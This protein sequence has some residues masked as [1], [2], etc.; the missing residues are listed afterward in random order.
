ME[1][2]ELSPITVSTGKRGILD[3]LAG[4]M[5]FN[6]YYGSAEISCTGVGGAACK[7]GCVPGCKDS[8]K[9]GGDCHIA[10]KEGCQE[11]CKQS[12]QGGNK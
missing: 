11:S 5:D 10:C 7:D 3:V 8:A 9:S 1:V 4:T 2:K 6:N 12:C